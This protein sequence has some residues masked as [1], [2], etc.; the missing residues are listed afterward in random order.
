MLWLMKL[1]LKWS[2]SVNPALLEC[3]LALR[4]PTLRRSICRLYAVCVQAIACKSAPTFIACLHVVIGSELRIVPGMQ[5]GCV[6]T[7][8]LVPRAYALVRPGVN[9]DLLALMPDLL[10]YFDKS[11]TPGVYLGGLQSLQYLAQLGVS[12]F[13]VSTAEVHMFL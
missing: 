7:V 9:Y 10:A 3:A 8:N 2:R 12:H 5:Q 1:R 11:I 13:V 4:M 6:D